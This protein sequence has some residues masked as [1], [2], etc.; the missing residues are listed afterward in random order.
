MK[1]LKRFNE[2]IGNEPKYTISMSVP[3][4]AYELLKKSGV[5]DESI[6]AAYTQY[7]KHSLGLTY[8]TDLDEFRAWCEESDNL[9]D[10]IGPK[11]KPKFRTLTD[12]EKEK[13]MSDALKMS[14]DQWMKKIS[15][16]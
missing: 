5:P 8:G 3:V 10:F 2:E 16:W 9:V 14:E 7:V 13:M 6:V 4:S 1:H 12:E 11:E 15:S